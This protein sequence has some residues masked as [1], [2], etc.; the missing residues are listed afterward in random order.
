MIIAIAK[1]YG[2]TSF[3]KSAIE[4][5]A[6]LQV[7]NIKSP[8][9]GVKFPSKTVITINTPRCTRSIPTWF[10]TGISIGVTKKNIG[11]PSV[12]KPSTRNV[13]KSKKRTVTGSDESKRTCSVIFWGICCQVNITENADIATITNNGGAEKRI[14][15]LQ[16]FSRCLKGLRHI[17]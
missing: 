14:V 7:K 6:M 3:A 12:I 8:N 5:S 1:I 4:H 17:S 2:H 9:G 13:N 16:I 15:S 10:A 11:N